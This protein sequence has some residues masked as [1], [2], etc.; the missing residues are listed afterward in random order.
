MTGQRG[1]V[2]Q[3]VVRKMSLEVRTVRAGNKDLGAVASRGKLF[4]FPSEYNLT[5]VWVAIAQMERINCDWSKS[6]YG[7]RFPLIVQGSSSF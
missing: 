2:A 6:I 5:R 1:S 3:R 4:L 7:T